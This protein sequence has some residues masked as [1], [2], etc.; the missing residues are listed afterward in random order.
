MPSDLLHQFQHLHNSN[1]QLIEI[2]EKNPQAPA[3]SLRV[4]SHVLVAHTIWLERI[5]EQNG[6]VLQPWNQIPKERFEELENDNHRNTLIVLQSEHFGFPLSKNIT[7]QNSK[8]QTYENSLAQILHHLLLHASHHRGQI[9]YILKSAGLTPAVTDY[10]FYCREHSLK[11][12]K[13]ANS[14]PE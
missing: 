4:F 12:K 11:P 1:Q 13:L 14:F 7:Y 3:E 8:G 2:F 9:A 5:F 6:A 10:I